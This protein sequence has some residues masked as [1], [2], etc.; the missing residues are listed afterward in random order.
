MYR[1]CYVNMRR[2]RETETRGRLGVGGVSACRHERQ[3]YH[4]VTDPTPFLNACMVVGFAQGMVSTS[5]LFSSSAGL[6]MY[7]QVM[8]LFLMCLVL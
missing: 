4:L 3:W 6:C 7:V 2:D 8:V 1:G 5:L